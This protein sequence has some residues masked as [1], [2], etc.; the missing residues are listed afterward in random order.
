MRECEEIYT[1]ACTLDPRF[2]LKWCKNESERSY[3][4][5]VL[6]SKMPSIDAKILFSFMESDEE[7][8]TFHGTNKSELDDYLI[9]HTIPDDSD[10]L[11]FWKDNESTYPNLAELA[12][13]YLAIPASSAPVERLFSIGGKIFVRIGAICLT[14]DLRC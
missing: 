12:K 5:G 13:K 7:H 14:K 3:Q 10:P 9:K 11:S 6:L 2:K 4:R 1:I 8:T